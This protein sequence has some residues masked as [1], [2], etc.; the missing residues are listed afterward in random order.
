MSTKKYLAMS[1]REQG[2]CHEKSRY[3]ETFDYYLNGLNAISVKS[4][5]G[6]A[7]G[8]ALGSALKREGI[9][10]SFWTADFGHAI[11]S[12]AA[13][14]LGGLVLEDDVLSAT[15]CYMDSFYNEEGE[16]GR[17]RKVS[18]FPISNERGNILLEGK[19]ML[20]EDNGV[21]DRAIEVSKGFQGSGVV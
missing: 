4:L 3:T 9:P 18:L 15:E 21:L 13:A 19:L 11:G 2:V 5:V 17:R 12:L 1:D 16:V 14:E 7:G 8:V 10:F 20:L 6:K